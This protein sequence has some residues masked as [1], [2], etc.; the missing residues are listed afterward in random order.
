MGADQASYRSFLLRLWRGEAG[1]A[2]VWRASLQDP[3]TGERIGF[4]SLEQLTAY[5]R[6]Q[7]N[8]SDKQPDNSEPGKEIDHD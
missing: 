6:D 3:H 4:A 7:I 8:G 5:L 2:S 1:D